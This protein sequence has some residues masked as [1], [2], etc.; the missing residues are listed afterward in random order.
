MVQN[1]SEA[2]SCFLEQFLFALIGYNWDY[3]VNCVNTLAQESF[4]KN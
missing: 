4:E 3:L 2:S 1:P